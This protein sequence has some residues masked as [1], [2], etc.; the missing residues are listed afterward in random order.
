M[1]SPFP[2]TPC[3]AYSPAPKQLCCIRIAPIT[4]E[5]SQGGPL[6]TFLP[7]AK[8]TRSSG[9]NIHFAVF[10]FS[11][12]TFSVY[13][14]VTGILRGYRT[15]SPVAY[16]QRSTPSIAQDRQNTSPRRPSPTS[17]HLL[18]SH[19]EYWEGPQCMFIDYVMTLCDQILR[20]AAQQNPGTNLIQNISPENDDQKS[21]PTKEAN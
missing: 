6:A 8:A 11:A 19:L 17:P 9:S 12:A 13:P 5:R 20:R 7:N 3:T 21:D 1:P 4:K 16:Y 2:T 15:N 18:S 14:A 10:V